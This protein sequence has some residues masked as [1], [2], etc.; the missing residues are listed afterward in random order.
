VALN[1]GSGTETSLRDLAIRLAR[2]MGRPGLAPIHEDERAVNPV[3]RR[4]ADVSK[5]KSLI[6]FEAKI[7]LD[8]GLR[9]LVDWW[10]QQPALATGAA[11]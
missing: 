7:P 10:T 6:G 11:V 4:L 3:P 2:V 5:A 9:D 8:E 1:V